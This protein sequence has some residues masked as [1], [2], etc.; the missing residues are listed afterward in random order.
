MQLEQRAAEWLDD[1]LRR[2]EKIR[3]VAA[4]S[5]PELVRG[6]SIWVVAIAGAVLGTVLESAG[7]LP[8]P[9]GLL[10]ALTVAIGGW[11]AWL[12]RKPAT[13]ERPAAPWPLV[14]V[15]NQRIVFLKR[16]LLGGDGEVV[17]ER[18]RSDLKRAKLDFHKR[19]T[20]RVTLVFDGGPEVRI[21]MH[22][23]KAVTDELIR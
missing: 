16:G 20:Y 17:L 6:R 19:N 7:V 21:E 22:R 15:T 12:L 5:Y 13:E 18:S 11:Y 1:E 8:S 4:G 9:L 10:V 3:A 14:A 23:A 2:G